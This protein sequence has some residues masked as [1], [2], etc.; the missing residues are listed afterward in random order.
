MS[1]Q[2]GNERTAAA[3]GVGSTSHP[4]KSERTG[5]WRPDRC[6]LQPSP[7]ANG[8][9]GS[10]GG[11]AHHQGPIRAASSRRLEV[12]QHLPQEQ[13]GRNFLSKKTLV[14]LFVVT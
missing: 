12:R 2:A 9:N 10:M 11:P 1:S 8:P 7:D 3:A 13:E 4:Q 6:L 5:S 14:S